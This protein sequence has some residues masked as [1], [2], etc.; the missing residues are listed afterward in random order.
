MTMP[1]FLTSLAAFAFLASV[2]VTAIADQ[3]EFQF[4]NG[5]SWRGDDGAAVT[6]V[7]VE[8]GVEQTMTG[9]LVEVNG[10]A[11]FRLIAVRG[12][13]AGGEATKA[14]FESDIVRMSASGD[15]PV[16]IEDRP[17]IDPSG[18]EDVDEVRDLAPRQG[19]DGLL[20]A[21]KPGVFFLPWEGQVGTLARHE[22]IEQ[23]AAEAD[24]YGPGQIIVLHINSPGG[25][26]LEG[27]E[28]HETLMEIKRRHR[29]IAWIK[30][31]ISAGAFT[32]LHC[33]EIYFEKVG[34]MGSAVMFA[35]TK[36]I[37]GAQL[38]A[39]VKDF[40][41]VAEA[42]GR[43]RIPAECMVTRTK[44]ASYD[45]DPETGKITWY[46]DMRGEH[47]ISNE[48]QVLTLNADNAFDSGYI[49]GIA[50]TEEQLAALLDLDE[51]YE[52]SDRGRKIHEDWHRLCERCKNDVRRINRDL[53]LR[54][55]RR[56]ALLEELLVWWNRCEPMMMW[57]L[58]RPGGS[59]DELR[60]TIERE[61]RARA[62]QRN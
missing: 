15:A 52:I 38:A 59:K 23:I 14:I 37:E 26:V 61:R 35:G 44:M 13:I 42:G 21:P 17:V 34:A 20:V 3:H 1:R 19:A 7:F 50:D 11:P 10:T 40:G 24:K 8:N 4:S 18:E 39:W 57:D 16:V 28:I 29:V 2:G 45:K 62:R 47:H 12:E 27:D 49:D 41:D 5:S 30:K 51:W 55:E 6:V 31:A 9:N 25:L 22:S 54:P 48:R 58:N 46:P 33:D 53:Q 32:A 60:R 56:L 43:S 36:S